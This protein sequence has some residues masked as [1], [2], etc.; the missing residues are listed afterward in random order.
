MRPTREEIEYYISDIGFEKTRERFHLNQKEVDSILIDKVYGESAYYC[1]NYKVV[2]N[3]WISISPCSS[4]DA[5]HLYRFIEKNYFKLK[6]RI[7]RNKYIINKRGVSAED[8]FHNSLL[9]IMKN[10]SAF[11]YESD[12]KTLFYIN[13]IIKRKAIDEIRNSETDKEKKDNIR[14]ILSS[15]NY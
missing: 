13:R 8:I 2:H 10:A 9:S 15:L 1:Q 11:I 5:C 12:N 6:N 14:N 3:E 7:V 4:P